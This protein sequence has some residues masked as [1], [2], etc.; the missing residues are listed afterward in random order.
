MRT[1]DDGDLRCRE[2]LQAHDGRSRA[3]SRQQHVGLHSFAGVARKQ[4][5]AAGD[6][7][8]LQALVHLLRAGRE[9]KRIGFQCDVLATWDPAAAKAPA[10]AGTLRR[11]C[12][13]PASIGSRPS[14]ASAARISWQAADTNAAAS[15]SATGAPRRDRTARPAAEPRAPAS[16]GSPADSIAR[17]KL[18]AWLSEL[19]QYRPSSPSPTAP[20]S[21]STIRAGRSSSASSCPDPRAASS[22]PAPG[23]HR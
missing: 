5:R 16:T 17:R 22:K 13:S 8:A 18:S 2:S 15:G 9:Y 7:L 10:R 12:F 6:R 1:T 11:H 3:R 14:A 20:V 21:R 19:I 4:G 23:R